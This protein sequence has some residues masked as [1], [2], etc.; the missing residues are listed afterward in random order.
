MNFFDGQGTRKPSITEVIGM[1]CEVNRYFELDLQKT[2][3]NHAL[4]VDSTN[5]DWSWTPGDQPTVKVTFGVSGFD[6]RGQPIAQETIISALD[7]SEAQLRD[8]ML[9]FVWEAPPKDT[10]MFRGVD[11]IAVE[12]KMSPPPL[13]PAIDAFVCII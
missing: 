2:L 3:N 5:V 11:S 10:N 9:N 1:L 6:E 8:F 13:N 12:A 7:L 4:R